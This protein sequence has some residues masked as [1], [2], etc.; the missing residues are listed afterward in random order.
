[1]KTSRLVRVAIKMLLD[2]P[3]K[4]ILRVAE[5]VPNLEKLRGKRS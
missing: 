1:L 4:E 3:M 5:E 2:A